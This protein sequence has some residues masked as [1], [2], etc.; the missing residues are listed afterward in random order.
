MKETT[1]IDLFVEVGK[2]RKTRD[3]QLFKLTTSKKQSWITACVGFGI[4]EYESNKF[5]GIK[6]NEDRTIVYDWQ[7]EDMLDEYPNVQ[8][9]SYEDN[10]HQSEIEIKKFDSLKEAVKFIFDLNKED[11][12]FLRTVKTIIKTEIFEDVVEL[13]S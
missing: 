4:V 10:F 2:D 7:M 11:K 9:E 12:I 6:Y 5:A 13:L 1:R 3:N 8:W